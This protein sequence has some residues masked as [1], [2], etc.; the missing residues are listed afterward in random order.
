MKEAT[1][2]KSREWPVRLLH[3]LTMCLCYTSWIPFSSVQI[4]LREP[5]KYLFM[6]FKEINENY[7][8][9]KKKKTPTKPNQTNK[10]PSQYGDF[11]VW[12]WHFIDFFLVSSCGYIWRQNTAVTGL[13]FYKGLNSLLSYA[14]IFELFLGKNHCLVNGILTLLLND[15][16][17]LKR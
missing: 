12:F 8:V 4:L 13:I 9:K 15:T 7:F 2:I 11:N 1:L 17:Q 16:T 14:E 5:V 3:R 6:M 10:K